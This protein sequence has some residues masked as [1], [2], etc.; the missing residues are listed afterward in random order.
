MTNTPKTELT[1]GPVLF[2]WPVE[3]W[4]DFYFRMADEAPVDVVYLGETVCLK[5]LPFIEP[6][7][8]DVAERLL[9]AGKQVVFST[10]AL[11]MNRQERKA[12]RSVAEGN[13]LTVE[14]NDASALVFLRG[15]PH[16]IGPYM[17]VYNEDTLEFLASE[18]A[19]RFC[20]PPEVP[21]GS[22]APLVARAAKLGLTLELFAYGR[23]P[24]AV[25]ARCYH[26][27]AHKLSKDNCQFICDRDPDGLELDTLD[28]EAFLTINGIQTMS[29]TCQNLLPNLAELQKAGIDAFRLSPHSNDMVTVAEQFRAVVDGRTSADEALARLEED[30]L[31]IPFSNGFLSGT[32]GSEWRG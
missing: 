17:N 27:R 22:L 26:A 6:H 12:L 2:N 18:G 32:A 19:S 3:T 4:R 24:L 29:Y 14:A 20:L 23:M 31:D 5:R 8:A 25:S 9:A 1:L 10:L 16:V 28:D 13:D 11:V 21:Q 7:L 30:G 15:R